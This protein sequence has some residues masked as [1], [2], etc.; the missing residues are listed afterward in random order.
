MSRIVIRPA[1]LPASST[2]SSFS[3]LARLRI[4]SASSSVVCGGALTRFS[5]VITSARRLSVDSR[6]LRSRRVRMP[7]SVWSGRVIGM[8]LTFWSRMTSWARATESSGC[9]VTGSRMT[10]LSERLTLC[11]SRVCAS[12]LRL[13]W[14]TPMPPSWASAIARVLSVTVSIGALMRGVFIRMLRVSRVPTSISRGWT[15]AR[16]GTSS[17]SSNVRACPTILDD[18]KWS[19]MGQDNTIERG[20]VKSRGAGTR[21]RENLSGGAIVGG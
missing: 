19:A 17:T 7:T 8:P 5:L 20:V 11:T 2:R 10:P 3:T 14:M 13:R 16:R 21:F 6:N 18:W 9:K 15:E 12:M 1:S 4:A